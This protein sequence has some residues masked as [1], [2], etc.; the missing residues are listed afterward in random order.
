MF[1]FPVS[2]TTESIAR[3]TVLLVTLLAIFEPPEIVNVSLGK[4]ILCAVPLSGAISKSCCAIK[5]SVKTL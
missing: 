1:V 2:V 3:V 4:I 5:F